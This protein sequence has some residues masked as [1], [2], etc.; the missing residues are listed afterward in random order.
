MTAELL[1]AAMH[2]RVY[3]LAHALEPGIPIHPNHPPFFMSLHQRFGDVV[4]SDGGSGAN[5]VMVLSGHHAT[6]V[7]ALGHMSCGGEVH[8]GIT[9]DEA[10]DGAK[11]LRVHAASDVPIFFSRGLCLDIARLRGRPLRAAEA[12]TA[13]DVED[14]LAAQELTIEPGDAV[15]VRTGWSQYWRE[16]DV[17]AGSRHGAPGPDLEAARLIADRGATVTGT[18]TMAYEVFN[19]SVG[20]LPVH[21]HLL[22]ERGVPIVEMLDLE[23]IARDRIGSFLFV[24]APL[25]LVGATGSPLRPLAIVG[26]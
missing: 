21:N 23:E 4:R 8:G 18:D 7:D 3:D 26:P 10:V 2:S 15:L 11:G 14:A 25:K 20:E 24:A 12:V 1:K 19:P 22:V 9:T 13:Q 6:H 5:E 16:P 17:F